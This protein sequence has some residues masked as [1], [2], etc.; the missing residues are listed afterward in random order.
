MS[1]LI[2]PRHILGGVLMPKAWITVHMVL[3]ALVEGVRYGLVL[4]DTT[5]NM[6]RVLEI[7]HP[8]KAVVTMKILFY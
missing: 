6:E 1:G 7:N 4:F 2:H 5:I 8:C 3:V